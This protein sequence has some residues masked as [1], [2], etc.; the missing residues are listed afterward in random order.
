MEYARNENLYKN[1]FLFSKYKDHKDNIK[2]KVFIGVSLDSV[3]VT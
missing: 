2:H 1:V 3:L